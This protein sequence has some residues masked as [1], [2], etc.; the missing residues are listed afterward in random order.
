MSINSRD[1][2]SYIEHR[3]VFQGKYDVPVQKAVPKPV[4]K[5]IFSDDEISERKPF[6]GLFD[7]VGKKNSDF[8][9]DYDEMV[10]SHSEANVKDM[11]F[12]EKDHV[13]VEFDSNGNI[14]G[15]RNSGVSSGAQ[16]KAE[17]S[18]R[19]VQHKRKGFFATLFGSGNSDP[20]G[21]DDDFHSD[22]SGGF[23][24][25]K[26]RQKDQGKSRDSPNSVMD[27]RLVLS[28]IDNILGRLS[29]SGL[30]II[31]QS[32]DY[33]VIDSMRKKYSQSSF[34]QPSG[35]SHPVVP[36]HHSVSSASIRESMAPH[37][38]PNDKM[39]QE[40][41]KTMGISSNGSFENRSSR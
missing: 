31:R 2:D 41:R 16:V 8:N 11:D 3:R 38:G 5:D 35:P 39:R 14:I 10:S 27:M 17:F 15:K 26:N 1:I 19:P 7:S 40:I 24:S 34:Q 37:S 18:G 36:E 4:R 23:F 33:A 22:D 21:F 9:D 29:P 28:S 25:K 20:D 6:F 12:S 30:E 32:G 13:D